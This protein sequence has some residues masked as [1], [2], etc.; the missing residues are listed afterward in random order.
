MRPFRHTSRS[1]DRTRGQSLAEFALVFPVLMLIIGGTIQFGIIFWGQNTLNQVVRDTGRW[2]ATQQTDCLPPG[3][4]AA[5]AAIQATAN[6]VA[7]KSALIGPLGPVVVDWTGTP[8][9]PQDNQDEAW[10]HITV[11]STVP[12]FFP[13]VPGSG[14]ISSETRFRMEP[15]AP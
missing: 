15:T 7:A 6:A 5:T 13:F 12:I 10:V 8:C 3:Q 2:A 4:A 14:A 1:R 9:P 11:T